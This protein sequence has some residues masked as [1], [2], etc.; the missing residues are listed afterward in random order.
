MTNLILF[1][2]GC[3]FGYACYL[4]YQ[5]C[6]YREKHEELKKEMGNI[7]KN[8]TEDE[9]RWN[10]FWNNVTEVQSACDILQNKLKAKHTAI[11]LDINI[12]PSSRISPSPY[13]FEINVWINLFFIEHPEIIVN[14]GDVITRLAK[15][16]DENTIKVICA[17]LYYEDYQ[18]QIDKIEILVE[19]YIEECKDSLKPDDYFE[20]KELLQAS[21]IE[22]DK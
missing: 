2:G 18:S 22:E 21:I 6:C 16:D 10:L 9:K 3:M 4:C 19:R 12:S 13:D 14:I 17:T 8:E 1:I 20:I 7:S 5:S 11:K 15:L